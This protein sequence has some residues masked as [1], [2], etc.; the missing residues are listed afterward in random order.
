MMHSTLS[1]NP[2]R[3]LLNNLEAIKQVMVEKHSASLKAEAKEATAA[4]ATAKGS[5]RSIL[6][7]EVLVNCKS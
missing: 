3:A 6:P 4:S 1:K 2:S 7:L 5:P